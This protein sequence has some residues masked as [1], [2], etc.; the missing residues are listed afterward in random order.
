MTAQHGFED[1]LNAKADHYTDQ[2]NDQ[3]YA[4][5]RNAMPKADVSRLRHD[6]ADRFD[7]TPFC[8]GD[9]YGRRTKRFGSVLT[10]STYAARFLT[11]ELV[12]AIARNILLPNCDRI[13]LNL[14]QCIAL[15]PGE[16]QQAPH[17]D[18]DMWRFGGPDLQYLLNVMWPLTPYTKEN[19]STVIWPGSHRSTDQGLPDYDPIQV[20]MEPGD[21][22]LFIGSTLH[23]GG[24][25]RTQSPRLGMVASYC[26]GWLRTYENNFL[27]YPPEVARTFS[28]NLAALLGYEQHRPNLG[29]VEGRSPMELLSDGGIPDYA[30]AKDYLPEWGCEQVKAWMSLRDQPLE[31][32]LRD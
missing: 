25:N 14:A 23:G 32:G 12:L 29:N 16:G 18:N 19:G 4:V 31:L 21:C 8:D 3:G 2:L 26:L 9:F 24:A 10:R 5:I 28:P 1:F 13:L 6:F 11:N 27:I 17:R 15:H 30:A 22:L 7:K 20:E